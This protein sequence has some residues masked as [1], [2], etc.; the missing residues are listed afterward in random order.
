MHH[1][2]V[3]HYSRLRSPVHRRDARIKVFV[4]LLFIALESNLGRFDL[5]G[6]ATLGLLPVLL[7]AVS[8]VPWRHLLKR[9]LLASPFILFVVVF[10]PF[11]VAGDVLWRGPWGLQ[12]SGP[13]LL[14]A[15]VL[16]VKFAAD[17]LM[18]LV[19]VTTTPFEE[20]A[21]ALRW[22]R[23]P[24]ALVEVLLMTFRYSFVL[25]DELERM[26]RTARLRGVG[27]APFGRRL[28]A[29]GRI[30]G[31]HL[32]RSLDRAERVY[33]AM[34]LRGFRSGL[35]RL[36]RWRLGLADLLF[37]ALSTAFIA[38]MFVWRITVT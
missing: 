3:D 2:P 33:Q 28:R 27:N 13:G 15:A 20:L 38:G 1:H 4:T 5:W 9:M 22:W 30:L 16:L 21:W 25:V 36:H 34:L 24:R 37:A 35:K 29:Y 18:T 32:L 12:V 23:V 8:E 26:V 7:A 31:A 19:L 10:Q 14:A 6:A 17:I 11:M